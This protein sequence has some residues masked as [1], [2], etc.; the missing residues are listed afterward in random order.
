MFF[1]IVMI[2]FFFYFIWEFLNVIDN[3]II[4]LILFIFFSFI[5]KKYL[6]KNKKNSVKEKENKEKRKRKRKDFVLGV[7]ENRFKN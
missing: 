3:F 6:I 5:L 2:K 1:R 7:L 4:F